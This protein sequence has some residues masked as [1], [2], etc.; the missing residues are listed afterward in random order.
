VSH[1]LVFFGMHKGLRGINNYTGVPLAEILR[2]KLNFTN[3][4][5]ARGMIAIGAKDAY[6]VVF[7]L[8]EILNRTDMAEVILLD[9]PDNEDG[10]FIV[11]PGIDFFGDRHLKGA[12]LAYIM[13]VE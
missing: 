11:H 4:D 9:E 5:L 7:S 10:R 13:L 6:R 2:Q 1:D 12:K 3:N 8:S